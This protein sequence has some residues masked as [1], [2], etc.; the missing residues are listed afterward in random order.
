M[1]W[2]KTSDDYPERHLELSDAAYRLHH[3]A[4]TYVNRL[5]LDGRLPRFHLGLV[6]VPTRTKRAATIT[7]LLAHGLWID[8]G[9]SWVLTDFLE[10]QPS[11]RVVEALRAYDAARQATRFATR[12]KDPAKVAAAKA[13]EQAARQKLFDARAEQRA[14]TSQSDSQSDSQRE[15]QRPDPTRPG[16]SRP[17]QTRTRTGGIRLLKGR[18]RDRAT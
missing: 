5:L 12:R 2:T 14:S 16:P 9:D 18:C 1:T 6:P 13:A 17:D 15:S 11:R 3:A 4:T 7:E 10:A 8:D